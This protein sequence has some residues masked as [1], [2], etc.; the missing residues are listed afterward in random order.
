LIEGVAPKEGPLEWT[1]RGDS[2][3]ALGRNGE[4]RA[5][6]QRAIELSRAPQVALARRAALFVRIGDWKSAFDDYER[7]MSQNPEDA[8]L[9]DELAFRL[10]TCPD[11]GY[12]DYRR[13][14]EL[15]RRAVD[16]AP[17]YS[18]HGN[19]LALALYRVHDWPGSVKAVLKWMKLTD[20]GDSGSWLLLAMC[21]WRLDQ[22]HRARQL[23][24]HA[25]RRIADRADQPEY[26][27]EL[28]DEARA[29]LGPPE[30]STVGFS[31]ESPDDPRAYALLLEIEPEAQWVY[32]LRV[33]A[34]IRLQ[35]WDQ[36]AA[37]SARRIQADSR[38]PHHW[39]TEAAAWL[40]AGDIA[41]YR[42]VR[43]GI[44]ARFHDTKEASV[45][46]HLSYV[47]A[48]VPAEPEE[49]EALLRFA[50]VSVLGAPVQPRIRGAMNYRAGRYEAAIA[51]LDRSALGFRRR[52]WDWL[53]LAMAHYKLGHADEAKKA[54]KKAEEWIER[55]DRLRAN[56]QGNPWFGWF[57]P[58]EVE[59][60]LKEARALVR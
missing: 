31:A 11:R 55:A 43:T 30:A 17:A 47:C 46:A 54:L 49:A 40:G 28:C 4:A 38:N 39:Y 58:L 15:A 13:A 25:L 32:T 45:A 16:L 5:S 22:K 1:H 41:G 14:A 34:C 3:V 10:C 29:L 21:Q 36:V 18:K 20:A 19:T 59:Q 23:Y 26:L 53:F 56:G 33:E 57:E 12:R 7:L 9:S 44:L 27:A 42:K 8:S 2:F 37:D 6:Y 24:V 51:D 48:A 50:D 35:Q 60:L 52:A